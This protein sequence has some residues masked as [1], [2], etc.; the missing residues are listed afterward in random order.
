MPLSQ[1]I[2]TLI[3]EAWTDGVP[4]LVATIGPEGPNLAPKGSMIVFDDQHLAWWERSKK[5][6]LANLQHD[7]RVCIMYANMK[8]QND[9]V[10]NASFLR[11]FGTV[12]LIESG[13]IHQKAFSMLKPREQ[14]HEGA[15]TGLCALV[16]IT[17]A[18][19]NRGKDLMAG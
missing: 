16:K 4:C 1:Q 11:F 5:G 15:D 2:K 19:D 7:K 18:I 8:L 9:G 13:P 3:N 10:M 14:T 12:E 17:K 6:A